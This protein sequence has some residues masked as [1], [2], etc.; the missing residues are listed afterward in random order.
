MIWVREFGIF[1]VNSVDILVGQV[2]DFKYLRCKKRSYTLDYCSLEPPEN[3]TDRGIEVLLT[4]YQIVKDKFENKNFI[5][6][7]INE[8]QSYLNINL[9]LKKITI[10]NN[11]RKLQVKEN[12]I[13][14]IEQY[15]NI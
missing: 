1:F 13:P 9:F 8:N 6:N 10:V 4:Y 7:L 15:F 11:I 12:S 14:L 3:K 2:L 5:S